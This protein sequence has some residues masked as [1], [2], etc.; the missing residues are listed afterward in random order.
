MT[1]RKFEY[2]NF[3]IYLETET[4][5]YLFLMYVHLWQILLP[6]WI[7]FTFSELI[8]FSDSTVGAA[9]LSKAFVNDITDWQHDVMLGEINQK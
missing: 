7:F 6:E 9:G 5:T 1:T 8:K 3:G 4:W 2:A